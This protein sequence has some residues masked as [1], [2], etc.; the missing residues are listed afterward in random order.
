MIRATFKRNFWLSLPW[1][2]LL[3]GKL[4]HPFCNFCERMRSILRICVVRDTMVQATCLP[5]ELMFKLS[6]VK[7]HL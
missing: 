4:L 6:F 5:T 2:E 7:L 1:N 3:V